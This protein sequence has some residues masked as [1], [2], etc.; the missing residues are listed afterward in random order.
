LQELDAFGLLSLMQDAADA[1][2]S[3][4]LATAS[5]LLQA[6]PLT[7]E[8]FLAAYQTHLRHALEAGFANAPEVA[9]AEI[10]TLRTEQ[11]PSSLSAAQKSW[12][13]HLEL[14]LLST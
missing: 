2:A 4:P 10:E 8:E 6:Q 11:Y 3:L 12:L 9:L 7:L 14:E 5:S 1:D 13:F